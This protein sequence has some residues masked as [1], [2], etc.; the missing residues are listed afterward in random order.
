MKECALSRI[1]ANLIRRVHGYVEKRVGE[2]NMFHVK[3]AGT[4]CVQNKKLALLRSDRIGVRFEN[5]LIVDQHNDGAGEDCNQGAGEQH[6]Q[7]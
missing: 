5:G 1:G 3:H 4:D 6:K 2:M 7:P